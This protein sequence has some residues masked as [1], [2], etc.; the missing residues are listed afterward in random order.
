MN[1]SADQNSQLILAAMIFAVSTTFIDQSIV[2]R[3]PPSA[4]P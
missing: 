4:R 2:A 1:E 3:A